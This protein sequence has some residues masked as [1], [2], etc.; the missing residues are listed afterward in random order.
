MPRPILIFDFDGTVALGDG[1][2]RAYARAVADEAGLGPAFVD[3]V[4]A[5]LAPGDVGAPSGGEAAI[6]AYDLVRLLATAAGASSEALARGYAASR[7]LL[8]TP[9]APIEVAAGLAD[10]LEGVD[11][12]RYLVTNAPAVRLPEAITA[13]GLDGCFDR[14]VAEAAKPEGLGRVLDAIDPAAPVLAIGDIWRNDLA[15]AHERGH[16][17]A[18]V[19]GYPDPLAT[20][21]F[22]AR[23]LPELLPA[24]TEWVQAPARTR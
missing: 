3:D 9:D 8:A 1:P 21:T 22:R 18:L 5:R 23:T 13:L 17:T 12:A 20:P 10:F 4:A 15:P 24:L 19:G 2:V 6:D 14:V 11:A 7:A 16:A